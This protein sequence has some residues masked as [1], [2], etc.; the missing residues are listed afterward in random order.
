MYGPKNK[1]NKFEKNL[2]VEI[3]STT[4]ATSHN[5]VVP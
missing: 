1:F 5:S 4:A 3:F 2:D